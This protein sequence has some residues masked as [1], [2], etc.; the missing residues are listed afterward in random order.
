MRAAFD[1][2]RCRGG[3]VAAI[4]GCAAAAVFAANGPIEQ[5]RVV[6][7]F[8]LTAVRGGTF[9]LRQHER[10][11]T[12][13]AFLATV[14]DTVDT[15]SRSQVAL[16]ESMY[17]QYGRRGLRVAIIDA[18]A[19]AVGHE[20][21]SDALINASYDWNL[22][23]PLLEDEAGRVAQM[24]GV[25][26]AP[27]IVLINADGTVAEVWVRPMAPGELAATIENALGGGPLTP[28]SA[29]QPAK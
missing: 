10:L 21:D 6:P 20:P 12:L 24:L 22:Q 23:I 26:H 16:L 18:T 14:P 1:W 2:C 19:L 29:T 27:T 25:T 7:D 15:P 8:S 9:A 5:G 13:I 11:P 17:H 4:A 3:V 28:G